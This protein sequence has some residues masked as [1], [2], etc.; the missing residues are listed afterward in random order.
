MHV[1]CLFLHVRSDRNL[2]VKVHGPR[3]ENIL[4]LIHEVLES[5]ITESFQ[6]VKYDY[7]IPCPDCI[8]KSVRLIAT[9]LWSL[10]FPIS[11]FSLIIIIASFCVWVISVKLAFG[12]DLVFT[13]NEDYFC[14][15]WSQAMT[16]DLVLPRDYWSVHTDRHRHRH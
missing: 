16:N 5:L 11:T 6:G 2:L 7:R 12:P 13:R 1:M 9:I 8:A 14:I 15:T 10:S 3:P 4:F